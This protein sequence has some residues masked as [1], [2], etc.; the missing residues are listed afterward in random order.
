M[1]HH[2]SDTTMTEEKCNAMFNREQN[3]PSRSLLNRKISV[4][5]VGRITNELIKI[6]EYINCVLLAHDD[7]RIENMNCNYCCDL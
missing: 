7:S 1:V 6:N 5:R 4:I 3:T 2:A